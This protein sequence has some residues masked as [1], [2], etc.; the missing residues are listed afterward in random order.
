MKNRGSLITRHLFTNLIDGVTRSWHCQNLVERHFNFCKK[1]IPRDVNELLTLCFYSDNPLGSCQPKLE[2]YPCISG[3][4]YA[5]QYNHSACT[6]LR[7]Y[8]YFKGSEIYLGLLICAIFLFNIGCLLTMWLC[9]KRRQKA[10]A[11]KKTIVAYDENT[12]I[13][14]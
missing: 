9:V 10:P 11:E 4:C 8:D 7:N 6:P 2:T 3:A 1:F 12:H 13:G 14:N 5:L